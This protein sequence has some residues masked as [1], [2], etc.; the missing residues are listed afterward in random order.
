MAT[1]CNYSEYSKICLDKKGRRRGT[2]NYN[3]EN[4]FMTPSNF[5]C[6]FRP[7]Y[8]T[9]CFIIDLPPIELQGGSQYYDFR[10]NINTVSGEFDIISDSKEEIELK[11]GRATFKR[12]NDHDYHWVFDFKQKCVCAQYGM[13]VYSTSADVSN[14]FSGKLKII[15]NLEVNCIST[16]VA[17]HEIDPFPPSTLLVDLSAQYSADKSFDNDNGYDDGLSDF[18]I[19][20]GGK[21]LKCH[22]F[23]L[24]CRSLV[25][26][27]MFSNNDM[28]EN[29]TNS[30][31]VNALDP[32][33]IPAMLIF[34]YTEQ[35]DKD[36]INIS[37]L[38]TANFYQVLGLKHI[39]ERKLSQDLNTANVVEL[40]KCSQ[41]YNAKMLEEFCFQFM[42]KNFKCIRSAPDFSE[43]VKE[44]PNVAV[45]LMR[46]VKIS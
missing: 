39:C 30:V 12:H 7:I 6:S 35:I 17:S 21:Q 25:F 36:K 45:E 44:Y 23:M 34:M 46:N 20:V 31:T 9:S 37:L 14:L 42:L 16:T 10:F 4:T 22:K 43:L 32:E 18:T 28:V 33:T 41:V 15:C 1:F 11:D 24:A 2:V 13:H 19:L 40:C 3:M 29:K 8:F 5:A 26:A 27:A 38:A